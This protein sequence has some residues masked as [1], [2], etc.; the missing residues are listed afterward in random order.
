MLK[1]LKPL[2]LYRM[3]YHNSNNDNN[4]INPHNVDDG[5]SHK[6]YLKQYLN[7][8][9][10][11]QRQNNSIHNHD[12]HQN[13]SNSYTITT[14]AAT[15]TTT[16]DNNKCNNNNTEK[17]KKKMK[18]S[19]SDYTHIA[20]IGIDLMVTKSDI[21]ISSTTSTTITTTTTTTTTTNTTPIPPTPS[22]ATAITTT[23]SP[24]ITNFKSYIV[25]VNNNPAMPAA[26]GKH[27][28]TPY[29]EHLVDFV[30]NIIQLSMISS[31]INDD[32]DGDDDDDD[33]D[34]GGDDDNITDGYDDNDNKNNDICN[35]DDHNSDFLGLLFST[36]RNRIND[37][38]YIKDILHFELIN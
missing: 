21:H 4:N 23:I 33:D 24:S 13:N 27:M 20:I 14:T 12:H 11:Q 17:K 2:L 31:Q 37:C 18:Q 8:I 25:E 36:N 3:N 10:Q 1:G 38:R 5:I 22:A 7:H 35:D 29:R 9:Y 30:S 6:T 19:R 16:N 32:D 28:S 15:T 26:S 34:E